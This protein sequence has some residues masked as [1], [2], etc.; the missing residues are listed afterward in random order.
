MKLALF[1]SVSIIVL[2][3]CNAIIISNYHSPEF[4]ISDFR[5][6]YTGATL[7]SQKKYLQ[8]YDLK[9]QFAIQKKLFPKLNFEQLLPFFSPP[10]IAFFL[11]PLALFKFN[12][13][14]LIFCLFLIFLL[15][16]TSLL[17]LQR[18]K[19][20]KKTKQLF[21]LGR[22]D[23]L[24][25]LI[26]LFPY[27]MNI[28]ITQLSFLWILSF[29]FTYL[30][31][32][33]KKY[34]RAGLILSLLSLKIH[35]LFVPLLFFVIIGQ[36]RVLKGIITGIF[37]LII[38]QIS[39]FGFATL[40]KYFEL[41]VSLNFY[42][43]RFGLNPS[44]QVSL[45]G[46]L[47]WFLQGKIDSYLIFDSWAIAIF[48]ILLSSII[49]WRNNQQILGRAII[50]LHWSGVILITLMTSPHTHYQDLALLIIPIFLILQYFLNDYLPLKKGLSKKFLFPFVKYVVFF[51]LI[52]FSA[53]TAYFPPLSIIVYI[54]LLYLTYKLISRINA[55]PLSRPERLK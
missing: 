49:F 38:L 12:T 15:I 24:I 25:L 22:Y 13:A 53:F 29:F 21:N 5:A 52:I 44:H 3:I 20:A 33:Q 55:V 31:L 19:I 1:S 51:L 14:Y 45:K 23:S 7:A 32:E 36:L 10:L 35:L 40:E 28:L 48:I 46:T 50:K 9:S 39:F 2:L 37:S 27:W 43:D 42:S 18:T 34:F 8:L 16:L 11:S 26:S 6:Q 17:F 4:T 54:I 30:F 47:Y 41:L